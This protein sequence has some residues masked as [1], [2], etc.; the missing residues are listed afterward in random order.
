MH[1]T[2]RWVVVCLLIVGACSM[3]LLGGQPP[4]TP[5]VSAP[6]IK[7]NLITVNTPTTL[8]V[9][10]SIP[11]PTLNPT[12][13]E[14]IRVNA[15]GTSAVVAE[16]E[17]KGKTGDQKPGDKVFTATIKLNEVQIDTL[18]FQV[19]ATFR[20]KTRTLSAIQKFPVLAP[21]T[22]PIVLPPDPGEPGKATLLGID[23]D[24]GCKPEPQKIPSLQIQPGQERV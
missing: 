17:D 16:M 15:N 10:V 4:A 19:A 22:I 1:R 9:T 5:T 24:G 2:L 3:W 18:G 8:V 21:Y 23:S 13:V 11:D 12:S 20:G 7:P 6:T 14:L